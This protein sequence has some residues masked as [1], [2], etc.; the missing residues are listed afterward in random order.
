[1]FGTAVGANGKKAS[2]GGS[3]DKRKTSSAPQVTT[4]VCWS[5]FE[6]TLSIV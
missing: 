1:M 5:L 4:Q 3:G 2:G 6:W